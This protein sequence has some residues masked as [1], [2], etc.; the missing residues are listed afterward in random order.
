MAQ[1]Q[2]QQFQGTDIEDILYTWI[3]KDSRVA[4]TISNAYSGNGGW[5]G[6]AQVEIANIIQSKPKYAQ[7]LTISRE[8]GVYDGSQK[9]SD[10]VLVDNATGH[11]TVI[12]LKCQRGT[13]ANDP[14]WIVKEVISDA[15][16]LHQSLK[17]Q[18]RPARCFAVGIAVTPQAI[19]EV[20]KDANWGQL[21]WRG[22]ACLH[23]QILVFWVE[24]EV[25]QQ[26]RL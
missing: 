26:G 23:D 9:R 7:K 3:E 19:A 12:E 21:R 25:Q 18:F 4:Q 24:F 15:N 1:Q 5:E 10:L 2:A 8:D 6:W 13:A 14:K 16:K 20:K 17:A 22:Q 11:K